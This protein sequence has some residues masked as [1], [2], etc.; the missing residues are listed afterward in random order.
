LS[1]LQCHQRRLITLLHSALT[2]VPPPQADVIAT[3][4]ITEEILFRGYLLERLGRLAGR[5]AVGVLGSLVAFGLV[6]LPAWGPGASIHITT[7]A[8]VVTGL[9]VW[10]RNLVACML[11]HLLNDGLAAFVFAPSA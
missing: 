9:Y 2:Q 1:R 6:H 10:R 5:G 11:V 8:A 7:W 3:A 4:G